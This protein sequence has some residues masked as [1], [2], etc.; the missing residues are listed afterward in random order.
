LPAGKDS[1]LNSGTPHRVVYGLDYLGQGR[2]WPIDS[3]D[4]N[5]ENEKNLIYSVDTW[6]DQVIHFIEEVI[7]PNHYDASSES[8][9]PSD[10]K[11]HLVGNSVGGLIAVLVALKR[12]DL[13]DSICL[14]N[15]TPVWGLNLPGWSGHLPPPPIPRWI[16]R[17]LFDKI[18]ERSTIEKY[19]S[20]AYAN[21]YAFGDDLVSI[22]SCVAQNNAFCTN[23]FL[24]FSISLSQLDCTNKKLYRRKRWACCICIYSLG[25]TGDLSRSK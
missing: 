6:T 10:F 14:L 12:P 9:K 17:Y 15:A 25:T 7:I 16:G 5:S 4:G 3:Q 18:R 13:V 2:S 21:P 22:M 20:T 8:N 24:I 11:L 19:L 23:T 1:N